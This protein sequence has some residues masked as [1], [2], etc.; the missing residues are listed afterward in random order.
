MFLNLKKLG[1]LMFTLSVWI[2]HGQDKQL[3][4]WKSGFLDVHY[5]NKGRGDTIFMVFSDGTTLL[6]DTSEKRKI[7]A[8]YG[9][10][11]AR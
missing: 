8:K 2:S 10:Y 4:D 11:K 1:F 3:S 6:D 5:I 7:R 9:P